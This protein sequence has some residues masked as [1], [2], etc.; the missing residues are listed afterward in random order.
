MAD[1]DR[2]LLGELQKE[3]SGMADEAAQ[4]ASLRWRLAEIELRQSAET[5]RRFSI[6][7]IIGAVLVLTSLPVFVV[8]LS[9]WL[10]PSLAWA[11]LSGLI[12]L[13]GGLAVAWFA[14]RRFRRDFHGL[15]QSLEEVREDLAW[16]KEW[17]GKAES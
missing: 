15:E 4:L 11:W 8:A 16:V 2:P 17:S 12:L 3:L 7:A 6:R 9:A 1:A 5:T 14:W 10:L 13:V